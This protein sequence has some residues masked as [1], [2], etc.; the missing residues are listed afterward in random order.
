MT[1]GLSHC[2]YRAVQEGLTNVLKHSAAASAC[3]VVTY[4]AAR[5]R[6]E[7]TDTGGSLGAASLPSS[8]V[9]LLGLRER[10]AMYGGT[11]RACPEGAGWRL[12]AE[13]PYEDLLSSSQASP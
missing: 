9:G 8:G 1:S 13:I 6:V 11:L 7:V 4:T 5:L 12:V 3:V 2:A 10:L